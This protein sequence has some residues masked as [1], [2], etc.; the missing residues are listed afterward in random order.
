M[1]LYN[2]LNGL[3]FSGGLLPM[4]EST[5]QSRLEALLPPCNHVTKLE[6]FT[7]GRPV[8]I[9]FCKPG[10]GRCGCGLRNFFLV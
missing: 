4:Q 5:D 1:L 8:Q 6:F 2:G 3:P 7:M 10:C 9:Y